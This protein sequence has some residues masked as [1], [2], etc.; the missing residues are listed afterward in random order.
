MNH[1]YFYQFQMSRRIF[2]QEVHVHFEG[3]VFFVKNVTKYATCSD[4]VHMFLLKSGL[5]IERISSYALFET[6]DDLERMLIG[7]TR[8][9][10]TL[11][12]WGCEK[13][14]FRLVLRNMEEDKSSRLNQCSAFTNS[15]DRNALC[16]GS[17]GS[18]M[19]NGEP[20]KYNVMTDSHET[21]ADTK[22]GTHIRY[23][24]TAVKEHHKPCDVRKSKGKQVCLRKYLSNLIPF[25]KQKRSLQT[26]SKSKE[27]TKTAH[28]EPSN[29]DSKD[30]FMAEIDDLLHNQFHSLEERCRYYWNSDNDSDAESDFEDESSVYRETDLNDAFLKGLTGH[31]SKLNGEAIFDDSDIDCCDLNDAF[32]KEFNILNVSSCLSDILNVSFES[33]VE[34]SECDLDRNI[35]S[36]DVVRN[37][38]SGHSPGGAIADD[39]EMDSFMRTHIY[40]SDSEESLF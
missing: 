10:K 26:D 17:P 30:Q 8:I 34:N 1:I 38:F 33:V 35:T 4:V 37:I 27:T 39:D 5:S 22:K 21:N 23:I 40:E 16:T 31:N 3:K 13:D 14:N 20:I 6:T 2:R 11:R 36:C 32:V 7:K 18:N 24:D 25:R 29:R 15:R 19:S 12:S 28:K 9:M